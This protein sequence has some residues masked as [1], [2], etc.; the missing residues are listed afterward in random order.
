MC[1]YMEVVYADAFIVSFH[2]KL[3]T[4]YFKGKVNRRVDFLLN[5]LFA[6]EEDNF[7]NYKRK[8]QLPVVNRDETIRHQNGLKIPIE[9]VEVF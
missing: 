5:V 4:T 3:K 2:N 8:C 6:I 7:F 9:K 1:D